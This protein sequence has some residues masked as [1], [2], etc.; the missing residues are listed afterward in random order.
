MENLETAY[1]PLPLQKIS[2]LIARL[3]KTK[4]GKYRLAALLDFFLI[5]LIIFYGTLLPQ[6]MVSPLI[7]PLKPLSQGKGGY[8]V[9]GFAPYW[10][11]DKLQNVNFNVLTTLAYF[12]VSVSS[13]GSLDKDGVG[14]RTFVSSDAT[15][16]FQ[17]AHSSGTRVVL[18]LTQMDNSQ[19]LALMD[20][21]GAQEKAIN[22]AVGEVKKRG[23]D[24]INV[25][26]EYQGDPGEAY[27]KKFS[28]F[29][30]NLTNKMHSEVPSSRVTVSVYASAVKE[31][32][33]YSI[34]ELSNA[35]DG[36]F[37]MAYDFAVAGSDNAIPTSPLYG[38]SSG[39]YWYDV[40]TAV[41]DFLTQMSPSKLILGV[42]YYGYNY[43]VSTPSV[44]AQTVGWASGVAQMYADAQDSIK[45]DNTELS[46]FETGWDND[47]KVSYKAYF[48]PATGAWRMIFLED[49]RSLAIKYDF[50]KEKH[51][52]G[53]GM[54]ALGFDG[55]KKELWDLLADKFGT[56]VAEASVVNR[57][58]PPVF[59][60]ENYI[61]E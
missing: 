12:G 7:S 56:K 30:S 48:A 16:I 8:E 25:D 41:S 1:G 59:A 28:A 11:F 57:I 52:E 15:R 54:W 46:G 18:T 34:G 10:T 5:L 22:D 33:I 36:I 37:M 32:K 26:F 29:V 23:I 13:G 39:K 50:A 17:K 60:K 31:P 6:G 24:G 38:A 27:R 61:N 2:S 42:P 53:V 40:S 14:Y 3:A 20:D 21:N 9:F 51:L 35:S 47:G 4:E 44:K 45:A 19:I 58:I 43:R 55:G 49:T